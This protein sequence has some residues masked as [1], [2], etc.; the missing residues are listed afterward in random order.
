MSDEQG[1]EATQ[2]AYEKAYRSLIFVM[3]TYEDGPVVD[4]ATESFRTIR[5]AYAK[6][7]ANEFASRA[8]L[9]RRLADELEEVIAKV[10]SQPSGSVLT[11]LNE[12]LEFAKK[13][14]D[15]LKG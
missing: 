11:N 9:L 1:V 12:A 10:E 4:E 3:S 7:V 13:A 8:K 14:L 6:A 15:E 2:L 5:R